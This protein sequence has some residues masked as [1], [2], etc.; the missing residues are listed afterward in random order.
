MYIHMFKHTRISIYIYTHIYIYTYIYIYIHLD[1]YLYS[2]STVYICQKISTH[3]VLSKPGM[4]GEILGKSGIPV[5]KRIGT[6]GGFHSHG[7]T[8]II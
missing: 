1:K 8:P 3:I 4:T 2:I 6:G 5:G 7:G